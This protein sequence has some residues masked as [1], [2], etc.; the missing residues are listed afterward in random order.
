MTGVHRIP[1]AAVI[2]FLAGAAPAFS[3]PFD[4]EAVPIGDYASL[5]VV[6]GS[7]VLTVTSE[8]AAGGV[9]V[10]EPLP[11]V[12]GLLGSRTAVGVTPLQTVPD[13]YDRLRF[14]FS[15]PIFSITFAFG[16]GSPDVDVPVQVYAYSAA[17][18]LLGTLAF[19]GDGSPGGTLSGAFDGASYF[20]VGSGSLNNNDN[21]LGWEVVDYST[22][23]VPEPTSLALLATGIALR[24]VRRRRK[25]SPM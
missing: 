17:D 13:S 16:D 19:G 3:G 22:E 9:W 15:V 11:A 4:F 18:A 25:V 6:D 10:R 12:S 24:A 2:A 21:S 14:S 5:S 1:A 23:A 8:T 20:L 7:V